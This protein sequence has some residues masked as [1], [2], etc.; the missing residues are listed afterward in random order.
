MTTLY[1]QSTKYHDALMRINYHRLNLISIKHA[2]KN[3]EPF[4]RDIQIH[5]LYL[6]YSRHT[7]QLYTNYSFSLEMQIVTI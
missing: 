3:L 5:T 6:L 2:N 4:N 7:K 1:S